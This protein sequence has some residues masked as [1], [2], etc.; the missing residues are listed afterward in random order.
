MPIS[1]NQGSKVIVQEINLSQVITAA[2]TSVAAQIIVSNKGDTTKPVLYTNAQDYLAAYG[3]PNARIS[4]DV[5]CGLDYFKEGNQLWALRVVGT[6]AL[7]S[8]VMAYEDQDGSTKL[9]SITGGIVDP[10][11]PSWDVLKSTYAPTAR[12]PIAL[13]YPGQG[14]GSYAND[15]MVAIRS[16]ALAA[17]AWPVAPDP[18]LPISSA[19]TGGILPAGTYQYQVSTIGP[20]GETVASSAQTIV[21]ATG[22]TNTN[23]V[24]LNW[25]PVAGAQGYKVYGRTQGANNMGYMITV[26]Q[27]GDSY[28]TFTDDGSIVPDTTQ[29][30][31]TDPSK[32]A[33]A[34][35]TFGVSVF[36]QSRSDQYPVEQFTCSLTDYTDSTGLETELE[37]AI[38]PFSQYIRVTSY[39]PLMDPAQPLPVITSTGPQ[40]MAGGNSGSAPLSTAVAGAWNVFANKQLYKVNILLNSGHSS[41]DVQLAMDTLAQQRG[42]CVALL[43]VPSNS[44]QFQQA[45]NYRNLRLNL[46]ST[47]SALFCPDVLE[48]DTINGKQQYVPFSGWAAALC[49]RTDRVA[50]PSFSIAG[51]NRGIVNVLG[52]RYTYDQGQMDALFQAQVNYTQTFVGQGTALWE[53]Q[54]LAA[55]MS[56]LSWLSVRRIVNVIKVALYQFLLYSLQEPNDD[57]TGR[58]IVQSCSDYLQTIKNARGISDFKVVSDA[59]NNTAQDFNS[60]IRNVTVIIIPV[61]PIHIINLQVVIS[62]QGVSFTEALSSV[63]GR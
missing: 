31:I 46:N 11:I 8:A 39:V 13:F 27:S 7:Y 61:I 22:G 28:I 41:P 36:L 33:A 60:G 44:Q 34:P 43:D 4:F 10:T 51:L 17:P 5:Y 45:I 55:Q 16:S 30:P 3:N 62:K 54:T 20:N 9:V 2:S 21:I 57:F 6:G 56:A 53:Q 49:A 25:K 26:G 40:A 24:V 59:S 47:Y 15:Y 48:A 32:A 38:N 50:N 29:P 18:T 42:D 1:A 23:K 37:Q 14:Q 58:Q 12:R 19:T 52:T 35:P 63:A